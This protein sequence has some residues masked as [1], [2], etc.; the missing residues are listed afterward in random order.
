MVLLSLWGGKT[1]G[2]NKINDLTHFCWTPALRSLWFVAAG[3]LSCSILCSSSW[4]QQQSH[5]HSFYHK[6]IDKFYCFEKYFASEALPAGCYNDLI[7][8]HRNNHSKIIPI[9]KNSSWDFDYLQDFLWFQPLLAPSL[10]EGKNAPLPCVSDLTGM[11][12]RSNFFHLISQL[13]SPFRVE[14][15]LFENCSVSQ[16]SENQ[17]YFFLLYSVHSCLNFPV[18]R[19]NFNLMC[20][21]HPPFSHWGYLLF[22]FP[23]SYHM[24]SHEIF[25]KT[26]C[27]H[28]WSCCFQGSIGG[29][30]WLYNI[31]RTDLE[32][33][34]LYWWGKQPQ[35]TQLKRR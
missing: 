8:Y 18:H 14:R 2:L 6:Q 5:I 19:A 29:K 16:V 30:D 4:P 7:S 1:A 25:W 17:L 13:P 11:Q 33:K 3:L 34:R 28:L 32:W 21:L 23:A 24:E 9:W 31:D 26:V 15:K 12:H 10:L 27:A 20:V 22:S 35:A